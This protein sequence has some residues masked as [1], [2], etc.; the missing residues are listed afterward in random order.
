MLLR[1][2]AALLLPAH[3]PPCFRP[4]T[5]LEYYLAHRA[6]R[7]EAILKSIVDGSASVQD[8]L[9]D[10]YSDV[11]E[12]MW[13]YAARNIEL[14]IEKLVHEGRLVEKNEFVAAV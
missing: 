14:H 2:G 6:K 3:G 5:L 4:Q 10:V 9:R 13:S 11:P 1:R 8:V 12:A 7:E